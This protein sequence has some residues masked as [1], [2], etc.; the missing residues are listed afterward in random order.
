MTQHSH[1]DR[2]PVTR[3]PDLSAVGATA[4]RLAASFGALD[5]FER[6]AAIRNEIDGSIVFTTSFGLEDQ[7]IA[8]AI[9]VR[10]LAI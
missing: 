3:S 5:L 8:H 1:T 6:L 10:N 4:A 2:R 7:A 9:F